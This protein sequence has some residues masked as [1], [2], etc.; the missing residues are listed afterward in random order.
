MFAAGD[1]VKFNLPIGMATS[2]LIWGAIEF[3]EAYQA[4][5]EWQNVLG[6]LRWILDFF[7]KCH[8]STN[9]LYGQVNT[10]YILHVA[11]CM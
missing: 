7:L 9:T 4:A 8:V 10:C 5:G 6:Q 3:Q 11:C 2:T 1:Y